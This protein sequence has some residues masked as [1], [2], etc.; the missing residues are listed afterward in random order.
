MLM[1]GRE[2]A[3]GQ[4]VFQP[5]GMLFKACSL[6]LLFLKCAEDTAA[7]IDDRTTEWLHPLSD[8]Q[9]IFEALHWAAEEFCVVATARKVRGLAE[10]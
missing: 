10:P 2:G 3:P 1:S 9:G 7:E 6:L 8:G 4:C 5:A